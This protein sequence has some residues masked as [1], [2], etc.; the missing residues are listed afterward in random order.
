M[1]VN[2]LIFTEIMSAEY[3]YGRSAG[4]YKIATE[5]RKAGYTCQV[6]DFFTKFSDEEMKKI[7]SSC[8]GKETLI[9]GFSSTFFKKIDDV[10]PATAAPWWAT[11]QYTANYPYSPKTMTKWFDEIKTINPNIKIVL[12]G[13]KAEILKAVGDAFAVGYCDQAIVE[14]M[15]YLEGKNPFFQFEKIN[16]TQIAF[17]GSKYT[18]KFEFNE[19]TI[20][21]HETDFLQQGETVPIEVA[22]GCI[23]KCKFCGFALNGKKKLDYI[24]EDRVLRDEFLKNYYEHG[25]TRYSYNDDTH[26]DSVEKLER[27]HKIVTSLPFE[28]EYFAFLRHDLIHAH[29]H[30]ATLLREAGL[31]AAVFGI[32]TL[33]YESAKS[34]GKGIHPEK[35]KELLYWLKEDVWKDEVSMGSGF[36]VGL[37]HDTPETVEKWSKWILDPACPL[38]SF[39]INPLR[40]RKVEGDEWASDF[41]KNSEKHGYVLGKNGDW[42]N[43]HFTLETAEAM[44]FNIVKDGIKINRFRFV[45]PVLMMLSNL[46][47]VPKALMKNQRTRALQQEIDQARLGYVSTYKEKLLK[48]RGQI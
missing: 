9:V 23:F 28:L 44:A 7:I 21:W 40:I 8:V 1:K 32:E 31:R 29:K 43:E 11:D 16:E 33:N 27:L 48:Y 36:I 45:G 38:N 47:Y 2:A 30:T 26:N 14:Y 46:G 24:K 42:S 13:A 4:A 39:S 6:V 10:A 5:I 19:S 22:R 34:I 15:K 37:P 17:Y 3:A 25:I 41:A 12:G 35:T 18:D 20:D